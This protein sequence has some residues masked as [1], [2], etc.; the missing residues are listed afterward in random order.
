MANLHKD[1]LQFYKSLQIP[2]GMHDDMKASYESLLRKI[3]IYFGGELHRYKPQFLMQGSFAMETLIQIDNEDCDLDVGC[4]FK[5]SEC[6]SLQPKTLIEWVYKAIKE[7]KGTKIE[8]K[9]KCI[10]VEYIGKGYHIDIPVYRKRDGDGPEADPEFADT[11]REIGKQFRKSSPMAVRYWFD[12]KKK[13]NEILVRLVCFLKAWSH[14]LRPY[15]EFPP[16]IAL[17]VLAAENQI[18]RD[19]GRDDIALARTLRAIKCKL[20][21]QFECIM[22]DTSR[23]NVLSK[24]KKKDRKKFMNALNVF[25]NDAY[26]A[27]LEPDEEEARKLWRKHLSDLF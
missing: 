4:Y 12:E 27:C 16:G 11:S 1:F 22:P 15:L 26:R 20:E 19:G 23:D 17:T 18:K 14:H 25:V 21:E 7:E 5:K 24:L 10:R 3:K 8:K 6:L 2:I 13:D 9:D